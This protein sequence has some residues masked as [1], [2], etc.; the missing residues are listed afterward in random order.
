MQ[1][2]LDSM[3]I[4]GQLPN[5]CFGM[6]RNQGK[7]AHQGWDLAAR[8]G[9]PVY[10]VA[11]GR[12]R[13]IRDDGDD[14]YG[15][16][17]TLE[18]SHNGQTLYAFYAHLSGVACAEGQVVLEGDLLGFTGKTGN[19]RNLPAADDHLHFEVRTLLWPKGGLNG[20]LDP[21]DL[22]GYQYYSSSV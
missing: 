21:G 9:T 14:G 16:H 1:N 15:V 4:R 18:F 2:P 20:R 8:V 6:V 12:I 3:R 7:R 17:V 5:H 10:A 13:Q 11:S 22:L 19:A